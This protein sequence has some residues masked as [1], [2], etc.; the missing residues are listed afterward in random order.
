MSRFAPFLLAVVCVT[1]AVGDAQA[2]GRRKSRCDAAPASSTC[3]PAGCYQ[4]C[5]HWY[6]DRDGNRVCTGYC[7]RCDYSAARGSMPMTCCEVDAR[8]RKYCTAWFGVEADP[9]FQWR[10]CTRNGIDY[11]DETRWVCR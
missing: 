1:Y 3:L 11:F 4:Y 8:G 7:T 5:C 2:F 9:C 6:Y 10:T